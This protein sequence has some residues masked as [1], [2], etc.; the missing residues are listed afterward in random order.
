MCVTFNKQLKSFP[1]GQI[2][3]L[4]FSA[5]KCENDNFRQ[6]IESLI[7]V[8]MQI[9]ALSVVT[10]LEQYS[11]GTDGACKADLLIFLLLR[12]KKFLIFH[13]YSKIKLDIKQTVW[14]MISSVGRHIFSQTS[15]LNRTYG[16]CELHVRHTVN[17]LRST[18]RN[19]INILFSSCVVLKC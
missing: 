5:A 10:L 18:N 6:K 17:G 16:L 4:K 3:P 8:I 14:F 7:N 9:T 13:L 2:T 1:Q 11:W 19:I 12:V 15:E